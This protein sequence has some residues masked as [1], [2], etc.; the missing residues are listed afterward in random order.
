MRLL[1][2]YIFLDID[3]VLTSARLHLATQK[4]GVWT[5]F[6]PATVI[7]LEKV[8]AK[9]PA[10]LIISSSWRHIYPMHEFHMLF[11]TSNAANYLHQN[12]CT[13]S[14]GSRRADE[15]ADWLSNHGGTDYNYLILDDEDHG[16]TD[17]QKNH[18]IRTDPDN[19]MLFEHYCQILDKTQLRGRL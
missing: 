2:N 11:G 14:D 17:E 4:Q 15:I 1:T 5:A 9:W 3:G 13:G 6:D 10:K 18:W 19:G 16:F 12:W 7:F 8:L